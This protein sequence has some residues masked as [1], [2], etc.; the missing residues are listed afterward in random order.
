MYNTG[1]TSRGPTT[2]KLVTRIVALNP[3]SVRQRPAFS[4]WIRFSC[5]EEE[6]AAVAECGDFER[7][8]S[9]A[10][11]EESVNA[12]AARIAVLTAKNKRVRF[13]RNSFPIQ[14]AKSLNMMSSNYL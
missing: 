9:L 8:A 10:T 7:K 5:K 13:E 12:I 4:T 14:F 1:A 11:T 2:S 6:V 3:L